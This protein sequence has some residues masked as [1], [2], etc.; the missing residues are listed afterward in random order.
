MGLGLSLTTVESALIIH[1]IGAPIL[2]LIISIVYFKK[3]NYTTPMQ[4]ASIFLL[5][6]I[7]MDAG[8]VAPFFEK[9]YDMFKSPLG[10]WI[11]FILIFIS[12]FSTGITIRKK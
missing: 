4:T 12:T 2:A 5:F 10:T 3:F 8:I 7:V 9:S 1:A 11:P 6:I